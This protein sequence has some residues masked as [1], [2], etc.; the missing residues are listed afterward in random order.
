VDGAVEVAMSGDGDL[1]VIR[2][3]VVELALPLHRLSTRVGTLDEVFVRRASG[4]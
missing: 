2:D 4:P 1:D 3:T